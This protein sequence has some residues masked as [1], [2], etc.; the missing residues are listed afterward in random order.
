M[1]EVLRGSEFEHVSP[2]FI[3]EFVV[4]FPV[5]V[6]DVR[7]GREF[8]METNKLQFYISCGGLYLKKLYE[9]SFL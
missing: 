2:R 7:S 9:V 6:N 1:E 4:I 3:H 5:N 8:L